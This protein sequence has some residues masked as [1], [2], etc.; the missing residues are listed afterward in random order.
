MVCMKTYETYEKY[1]YT[2]KAL[3][4]TC[5]N[6]TKVLGMFAQIKLQECSFIVTFTGLSPQSRN[7]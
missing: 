5:I 7:S 1:I 6:T 2:K 3:C 4:F